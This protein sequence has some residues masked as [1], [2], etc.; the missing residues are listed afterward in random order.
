MIVHFVRNLANKSCFLLKKRIAARTFLS[1]HQMPHILSGMCFC[2]FPEKP[3]VL[4]V[5]MSYNTDAH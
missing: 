1:S 5:Q 4:S 2:R 3:L